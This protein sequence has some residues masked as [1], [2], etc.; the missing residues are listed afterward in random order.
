MGHERRSGQ[1]SQ[2]R[3]CESKVSDR[4]AYLPAGRSTNTEFFLQF[5][6]AV[7]GDAQFGLRLVF[8]PDDR[9][10]DSRIQLLHERDV[11]NRGAVNPYE[12]AGIQPL[13]ELGERRLDRVLAASGHRER[14][15]V[16]S[17]KM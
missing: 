13:L 12:S 11:D 10:F 17:E 1:E 16:A 5:A 7:T 4:P 15:L 2:E 3:A 14:E 9:A 6:D 8:Q